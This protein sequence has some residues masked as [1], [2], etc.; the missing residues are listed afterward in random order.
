M[1]ELNTIVQFFSALYVTITIDSLMFKRFW[2]PDIYHVIDKKLK[3]Y[4]FALSTPAKD[5]LMGVI[6]GY[7]NNIDN[8]SR[9]RGG[10]F[11]LLC[12]TLL[13]LFA[14]ENSFANEGALLLAVLIGTLISVIIYFVGI[15][16]WQSWKNIFCS[17]AIIMLSFIC[18]YFVLSMECV[19][20]SNWGTWIN[21]SKDGICFVSKLSIISLLL[22]PILIRLYINWLNSTVYV[23]YIVGKLQNEYDAYAK[24]KSA[25]EKRDKTMVDNRYD[26]IYKTLFFAESSSQDQVYTALVDKLVVYLKEVCK[27][28][29]TWEL[30]KYRYSKEYKENKDVVKE[31]KPTS[32]PLPGTATNIV[33]ELQKANDKVADG[34]SLEFLCVE[35]SKCPGVSISKFC[36]EKKIEEYRFKEYRKEWLKQKNVK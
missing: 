30:L 10:Y 32:Y 18:C 1:N 11:L 28:V 13:I 22:F 29:S 17:Y 26:S 23:H 4:Q 24:T 33:T 16:K 34:N 36:K 14:F 19:T 3:E 35:Y 2:T 20:R 25:I 31:N 6:K 21:D 7:A 15:Y 27:P 5:N 9:R 12:I 8:Q